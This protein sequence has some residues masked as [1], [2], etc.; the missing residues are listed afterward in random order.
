MEP[1]QLFELAS[2]QAQWLTVRQNVVAGNI[3]NANTPHY[4]AKDVQPFESV[5]QNT[6]IQMAATHRAHFTESPEAAHVT[7]VSA[8]D[9]V[10]VQQSGNTVA[11]EEELMKTG[12]IKRDYELNAG[13]VKSFHRMIL[14]TVRK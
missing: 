8:L 5:L 6:G 2:R 3:A 12:A 9:D 14:M 10:A 1:I 11:L 13:L 4:R 7:E